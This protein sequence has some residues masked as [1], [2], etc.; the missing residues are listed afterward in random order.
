MDGPRFCCR[1]TGRV[2]VHGL[3]L[4]SVCPT[5]GVDSLLSNSGCTLC[6][7]WSVRGTADGSRHA[8]ARVSRTHAVIPGRG[9]HVS[10]AAR[11]G[12]AAGVGWARGYP[13]RG[14]YIA[15]VGWAPTLGDGDARL[16]RVPTRVPGVCRASAAGA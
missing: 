3:C 6:A 10:V 13:A 16:P 14:L 7:V 5:E 1:W 4:F 9:V 2:S 12:A 8:A 11:R 15:G